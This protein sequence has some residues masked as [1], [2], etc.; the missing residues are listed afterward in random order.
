MWEVK[1][2]R[3]V[4]RW[5][6]LNVGKLE[7]VFDVDT[8]ERFCLEKGRTTLEVIIKRVERITGKSCS[9][10]TRLDCFNLF[11]NETE[12]LPLYRNRANTYLS[13]NGMST[14][15]DEEMIHFLMSMIEISAHNCSIDLALDGECT[16]F[17]QVSFRALN[18][19]LERFCEV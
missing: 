10:L 18:E 6:I 5:R 13:K 8:V 12:V 1:R 4:V 15:T 17:S 2:R 19:E 3:T 7:H 16:H 9:Q 14:S 11:F